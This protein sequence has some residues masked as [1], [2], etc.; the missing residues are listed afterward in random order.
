MC[1]GVSKKPKRFSLSEILYFR[2]NNVFLN[3]RLV[4]YTITIVYLSVHTFRLDFFCILK[5]DEYVPHTWQYCKF[6]QTLTVS[7][8]C[9][10]HRGS[11]IVRLEWE[12]GRV[13][14]MVVPYVGERLHCVSV[15]KFLLSEWALYYKTSNKS[16]KLTN[17]LHPT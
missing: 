10:N 6:C 16:L 8:L 11:R 3:R 14:D 12:D 15:Q 4:H 7:K 5:W 9:S 17:L 13:S 1:N 2:I